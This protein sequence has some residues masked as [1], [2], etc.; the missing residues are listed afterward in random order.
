MPRLRPSWLPSLAALLC[1]ALTAGLGQWQWQK[2]ER[3]LALRA[4]FS[5]AHQLP[6]LDWTQ[7]QALGEAALYRRVRVDGEFVAPFQIWLD[8]RVQGGRAGY[9]VVTPLRLD[10]G[11]SL[12][13]NRGWHAAA[14]D[15]SRLPP[16]TTP[17]ARQ[18]VEGIL[19]RAQNRY[20]ELAAGT[21]TQPVWQNLDLARYRAWFDAQLPDWLLLQ[22]SPA[23]DGLVRDWPLPDVGVEKHR[24]YAVQWFLLCAMSLGLW[25]NFML[26]RQKKS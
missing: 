25:L 26:R 16:L 23:S 15:R 14:S 21:Q 4:N 1:A 17:S 8:N 10:R 5:L 22:T 11:A 18:S 2:A 7:V 19:V 3:K 13:V 24:T 9:H 6:P 20:L 12:L